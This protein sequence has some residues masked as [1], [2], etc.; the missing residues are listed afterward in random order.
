[1]RGHRR[2]RRPQ[3]LSAVRFRR[4]LRL[5]RGPDL[6]FGDVNGR[7]VICAQRGADADRMLLKTVAAVRPLPKLK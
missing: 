5:I 2:R 4:A 6:E 7:L 1:M 3:G